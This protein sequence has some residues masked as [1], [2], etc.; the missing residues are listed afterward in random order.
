MLTHLSQAE[1]LRWGAKSMAVLGDQK[2]KL[3][4]YLVNFR[5]WMMRLVSPL[6]DTIIHTCAD[7]ANELVIIQIRSNKGLNLRAECHCL[8]SLCTSRNDQ[9]VELFL[10]PR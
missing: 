5:V 9:K 10:K 6:K 8:S 1:L 3:P 4:C 2:S 7:H